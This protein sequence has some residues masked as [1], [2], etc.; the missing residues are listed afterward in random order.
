[1]TLTYFYVL[2]LTKSNQHCRI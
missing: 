1:V 2:Q